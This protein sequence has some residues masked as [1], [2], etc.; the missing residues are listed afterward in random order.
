M[1]FDNKNFYP[2]PDNVIEKMLE[3]INLNSSM[4]ILDPSAGKGNILNYIKSDCKYVRKLYA[5][6][7]DLE[8][9]AILTGL[10]YK[11]IDKDFLNY[12][13]EK[14]FDLIIMNPPFDNADKHLLKALEIANGADSRLFMKKTK[15]T[16][17]VGRLIKV[18]K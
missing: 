16:L 2:T 3:G 10:G 9:Q 7:I 4:S 15:Y 8:L 13:P 5:I 12:A 1:I 6:E 17:R 18:G 14:S 11:I